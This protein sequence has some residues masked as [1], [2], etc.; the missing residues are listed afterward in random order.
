MNQQKG[1]DIMSIS[2]LY[3]DHRDVIFTIDPSE[4]DERIKDF[5]R[6]LEGTI[7]HLSDSKK[8]QM[9]TSDELAYHSIIQVAYN[10]DIESLARSNIL[11][12]GGTHYVSNGT[13]SVG[14]NSREQIPSNFIVKYPVEGDKLDVLDLKKIQFDPETGKNSLRKSDGSVLEID[15]NKVKFFDLDNNL[16]R[17]NFETG[18]VFN[19][20]GTPYELKYDYSKDKWGKHLSEEETIRFAQVLKQVGPDQITHFKDECYSRIVELIK[21]YTDPDEMYTNEQ[22]GVKIT[23]LK[24]QIGHSGIPYRKVLEVELEDL[25]GFIAL[26]REKNIVDT[27]IKVGSASPDEWRKT[28]GKYV[29]QL[30]SEQEQI[31]YLGKKLDDLK[32]KAIRLNLGPFTFIPNSYVER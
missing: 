1:I 25:S 31:E 3:R 27:K 15:L 22:D 28:F 10:P 30:M 11:F 18:K 4:S 7:K 12:P 20:D 24:N 29:N 14:L 32:G 13:V 6:S 5:M 16:L 2:D 9:V 17:S 19:S 8:G 26:D 21:W 23:V